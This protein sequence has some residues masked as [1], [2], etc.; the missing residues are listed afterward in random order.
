M[1]KAIRK[2]ENTLASPSNGFHRS[3]LEVGL[4][5]DANASMYPSFVLG[6]VGGRTALDSRTTTYY[7]MVLAGELTLTREGLPPI[8]LGPRMYFAATGAAEVSGEGQ[9][10]L[11]C[12]EG[13]RAP[14][15]VGG[16][17]EPTG[18]LVYIDNCSVSQLSPPA[19]LGDPT[20]Q[21]LV[22]PPNVRQASH[23]H[24]TLRF[25]MVVRG[26]GECRLGNDVRILL[27]SGDVFFIDERAEHGFSTG[28]EGM[29]VVAYH[30]D[31][32]VGPTDQ[33][34]PMLSRTY[35]RP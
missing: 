22:F 20:L 26:R 24:P 30:P 5:F 10:A 6:H 2:N 19:R 34:H 3:S 23:I 29:S 18:R 4:I 14:F 21:L 16:P 35:V 17:V 9:A 1:I 13:Y 31:S 28:Q 15:I 12:R 27:E 11:F 32:D 8:G 7:G 25:G 33:E